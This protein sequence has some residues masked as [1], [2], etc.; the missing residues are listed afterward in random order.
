M[1]WSLSWSL[2]CWANAED[3]TG[4]KGQAGSLATI[5]G[6]LGGDLERGPAG[7]YNTPYSSPF[8]SDQALILLLRLAP[9][10][11]NTLPSQ[12]THSLSVLCTYFTERYI[13]I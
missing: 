5:E 13:L 9:N 4:L 1:S 2:S 8:A 7:M 11:N 6:F 10:A 3:K 12:P